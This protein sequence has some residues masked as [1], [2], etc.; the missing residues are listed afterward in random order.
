MKCQQY[1][2]PVRNLAGSARRARRERPL[3][4]QAGQ[5]LGHVHHERW[6][7]GGWQDALSSILQGQHE[8]LGLDRGS[9][10]QDIRLRLSGDPGLAVQQQHGVQG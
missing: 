1:R 3:R 10:Y 9:N 7:H 8:L 5:Q 4:Q 6:L 2:S